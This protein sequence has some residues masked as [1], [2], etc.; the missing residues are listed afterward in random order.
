LTAVLRDVTSDVRRNVRSRKE[1]T[2]G[3][4]F[5]AQGANLAQDVANLYADARCL[6]PG[7]ERWGGASLVSGSRSLV[8][9]KP[10]VGAAE[11]TVLVLAVARVPCRNGL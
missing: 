2:P 9:M 4:P 7:V 8:S 3:P 10:S 1:G 6:A 5:A 11:R